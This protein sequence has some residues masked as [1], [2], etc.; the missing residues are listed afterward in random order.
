MND[1]RFPSIIMDDRV[2]K[3]FSSREKTSGEA[4]DM[5]TSEY[6]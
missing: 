2:L 1:G 3:I 6:M 4:S 5:I